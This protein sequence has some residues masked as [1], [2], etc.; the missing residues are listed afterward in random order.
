MHRD[1][2]AYL[3]DVQEAAEAIKKFIAGMDFET[4]SQNEVV[5][6]AVERKFGI[7]GEALSNCPRPILNSRVAY[8][9]SMPLWPFA[10]S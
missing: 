1:A 4:Y 3:W 2:R 8:P 10:I 5:H 6:A 7:I 9:M